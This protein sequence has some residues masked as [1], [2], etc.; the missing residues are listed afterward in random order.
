MSTRCSIHI[1][2]SDNTFKM[3]Y[4]HCDGYL[5]GV[6]EALWVLPKKK[7]TNLKSIMSSLGKRFGHEY[8][9]SN[10]PEYSEE[11]KVVEIEIDF[12]KSRLEILKE[13]PMDIEWRYRILNNGN[14]EIDSINSG[15]TFKVANRRHFDNLVRHTEE[16]LD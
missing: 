6:G 3:Y 8:V 14:L 15:E 5:S 13:D 10:Y 12:N 2:Q 4:H 1:Q 16:E 11:Q 9:L 7:R